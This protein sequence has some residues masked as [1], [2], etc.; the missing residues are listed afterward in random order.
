M[1]RSHQSHQEKVGIA[2]FLS[3][4]RHNIASVLFSLLIL[5]LP[6]QFGK[7]F[8]PDFAIVSG[9]RVD[10]LSPTLYLTDILLLLLSVTWMITHIPHAWKGVR[11]ARKRGIGILSFPS[12]YVLFVGLLLLNVAFSSH[13]FNG[14][15]QVVK[16]LE[17]SFLTFYISSTVKRV[18]QVRQ[19]FF[20]LGIGVIVESG[21]AI[22][23]FVKQGALGGPFY[24]LG[25]RWFTGI[26]PGIANASLNGELVLRSYGTFPHPNVLAGFLL[27]VMTFLLFSIPWRKKPAEKFVWVLALFFGSSALLLTMSRLAVILWVALLTIVFLKQKGYRVV[28]S[29]LAAGVILSLVLLTTFGA[30]F[31]QTTLAEEAVT[32]RIDLIRSSM[33]LFFREPFMGIGLGNFLPLLATLPLSPA[34]VFNLQPVHNIFILILVETGIIGFGLCV[35]F[36]VRLY[37]RLFLLVKTSSEVRFAYRIFLVLLTLL[38]ILGS[39]DH[40]FLT[41]QQGQL[42]L[43]LII[44]LGLTRLTEN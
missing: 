35:W 40:Y 15:Y 42:L 24:F 43:A 33:A 41:L 23:Q 1:S 30:R 3:N 17:F 20:L 4:P 18:G 32:L 13:P 2:S 8:W 28:R 38:L 37:R 14:M 25:E 12:L 6:S 21:I 9:I 16:F 22:F 34:S 27:I 44:G 11:Q 26:T 29:I 7:H 10:Y 5:F 39:V 19:I 31:L 36:L